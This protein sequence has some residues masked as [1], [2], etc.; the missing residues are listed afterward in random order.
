MTELL[1][2][3]EL[4]LDPVQRMKSEPARPLVSVIICAYTEDRWP[5]LMRAL[6]SVR[7]QT[8]TPIEIILCID[9]NPALLERCRVFA[10][11]GDENGGAGQRIP[12]RVMANRYSGRLGSARNSA[13]DVASGEILAFLDDDAWADPDWLEHLIPPYASDRTVAVGGAPIPYFESVRPAWFP[14]EF[15][16]VFGCAY[17]GLPQRRERC[18]RLI[19]A[20]MSVRA[21]ALKAI[22]GFHSDDHDD[23]DMCHRLA[24]IRP[25]DEIL[26]EP[27]A[28]VHHF[29]PDQRTRW[30]Y[31]CR[32]C[33]SVNRGK[34]GAYRQMEEAA[35]HSADVRFVMTALFRGVSSSLKVAALGDPWGLARAASIPAGILIA[36]AGHIVGLMQWQLAERRARDR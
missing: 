21:G 2:P 3:V 14:L 9:H 29:V 31:F 18:A 36:G 12:V 20:N 1:D 27:D 33:F 22:G 32:R 23:M 17:A 15:D 35:D 24:H 7:H 28:K 25:D 5:L 6:E 11:D 16:W 4:T 30:G 19:G 26:Y 34:V 13:A 8:V 10:S